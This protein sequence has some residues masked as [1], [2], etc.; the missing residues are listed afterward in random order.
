MIQQLIEELSK[1]FTVDNLV[2]MNEVCRRVP[3]YD[4][5]TPLFIIESLLL[6]MIN[7]REGDS[8]PE[9]QIREQ[10]HKLREIMIKIVQNHDNQV[11]YE[12]CN[13]LVKVF[14]EYYRGTT[15]V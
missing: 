10:D 3:P 6:R 5:S 4:Y 13:K 9:E 2:A 7:L 11:V 15:S 12:L 8:M 1:D 14:A